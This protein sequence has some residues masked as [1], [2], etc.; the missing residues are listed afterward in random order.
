MRKTLLGILVLAGL[1][2]AVAFSSYGLNGKRTSFDREDVNP[3]THLR[4]NEGDGT[5]QFAIVSDR[6]GGHRANIFAQAVHKLNLM[7][8]SFVVSVGD[9]IE[10]G[11]KTSV[12]LQK[13]WEE[14]DGLVN[15][16]SMPF[17]YVPGNH[18]TGAK[19]S[20]KVWDDKLGRRRYHFVYR[21]VL[22]LVLDSDDPPEKQ[23]AIS[24]EQAAWAKKV[25]D[26]QADVR[27]TLVFVHRP[28]WAVGNGAKN[29]WKDVEDALAG[30]KYTVFAGHVHRFQKYMRNGQAYYQLATTG[31]S[32][33]MRGVEQGEFD[34]ITWVTM[35]QD[36]PVL[37]H[38]TLDAVHAENLQA[39]ATNEPGVKRTRLPVHPVQGWAY[40][41]GT[42]M[43]GAVLAFTP[44][45]DKKGVAARGVVQAD[46]SFTLTTYQDSDGAVEGEYAVTATWRE[47]SRK[48]QTGASLLPERY[49]KADQ[50]GLR[51]T[52]RAERNVVTLELRK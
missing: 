18:D 26:A 36:G 27:W 15:Q 11:K 39:P 21:K 40:Y 19:E 3:V 12:Q 24:A 45:A 38:I 46:G 34:H 7:Q 28:L 33:V 10:G 48:G 8:P 9:L 14:F 30:R 41:Q 1:G 2:G 52:I 17:F 22:F 43:P 5:F 50:S 13:E 44:L 32:S 16:L 37:A 51:A 47:K 31:G 25:L 4:W 20:A 42:P 6:T 23:G 49:G 35:K 29:G